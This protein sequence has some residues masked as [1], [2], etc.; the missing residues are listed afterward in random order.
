M[1]SKKNKFLNHLKI[2]YGID[3]SNAHGIYNE[4]INL[5]HQLLTMIDL[6]PLRTIDN[7]YRNILFDYIQ[8]NI[9]E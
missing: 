6:N 2:T 9:I 3:D 1:I 7:G 8:L 4:A 5:Y